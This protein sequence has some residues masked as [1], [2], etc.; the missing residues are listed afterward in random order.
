LHGLLIV[1]IVAA[2][3]TPAVAHCLDVDGR[4]KARA[5]MLEGLELGLRQHTAT[6]YENRLRDRERDP[7]RIQRG[8]RNA[9][10]TYTRSRAEVLRWSPPICKETPP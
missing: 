9:V 8:M 3:S 4:E 1:L 5:L 6:L 10:I 7:A 2:W